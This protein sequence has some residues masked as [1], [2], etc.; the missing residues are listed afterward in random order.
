[1]TFLE[2]LFHGV[3]FAKLAAEG[4]PFR[5]TEVGIVSMALFVEAFFVG[6]L[7]AVVRNTLAR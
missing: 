5:L 2:S 7:F 4:Q 3:Q 6:W 1:M